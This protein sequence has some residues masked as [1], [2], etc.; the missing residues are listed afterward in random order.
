MSLMSFEV[1]TSPNLRTITPLSG[2]SGLASIWKSSSNDLFTAPSSPEVS[3]SSILSVMCM[4]VPRT[5][6]KSLYVPPRIESPK[7]KKS[8]PKAVDYIYSSV[9]FT[10]SEN[11]IFDD[12]YLKEKTFVYKGMENQEFAWSDFKRIVPQAEQSVVATSNLVFYFKK[13]NAYGKALTSS[14]QSKLD[15]ACGDSSDIS[16]EIAVKILDDMAKSE[17]FLIYSTSSFNYS[18][19]TPIIKK[20]IK[21]GS[22]SGPLHRHIFSGY[23]FPTL[24]DA[25]Q[26]VYEDE[27]AI[28]KYMVSLH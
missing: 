16:I 14:A 8:K 27:K 15:K 24:I 11:P 25:L 3:T 9:S 12:V 2:D 5:P 10:S 19:V 28:K 13:G 7:P 20:Y 1:P 26:R 17:K 4:N 18:T 22:Q 6:K 23:L 21:M